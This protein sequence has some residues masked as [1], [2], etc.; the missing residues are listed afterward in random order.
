MTDLIRRAFVLLAPLALAACAAPIAQQ[1]QAGFLSSYE[2]LVPIGKMAH[3]FTSDAIA[4]YRKLLID[5]PVFLLDDAGA[6]ESPMFTEDELNEL[7]QHVRD[8]LIKVLASDERFELVETAGPGVGRV[9][10][11]FTAIDAS[12]GILNLTLYTKVTGAGLGGAA[13]EGEIVDAA[14]NEQLSATVQWGNDSRFLRAGL[15]RL[16][17]AKLQVNR[18][19]KDLRQRIDDID[20]AR[21][22]AGE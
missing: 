14:T 22:N 11:A 18:W 15:T 16:G 20:E 21:I 1:K 4:D 2:Q 9:R 12:L 7:R 5:E 10:L 19:A 8:R 6:D 17:G 13:I 3:H